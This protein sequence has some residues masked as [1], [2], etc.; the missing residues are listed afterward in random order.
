MKSIS[1]NLANFVP[2]HLTTYTQFTS[3][4]AIEDKIT[5]PALAYNIKNIPVEMPF[6]WSYDGIF[7][8]AN[9]R[10]P[11]MTENIHQLKKD[12]DESIDKT[13]P[14][15]ATQYPIFFLTGIFFILLSIF[16]NLILKFKYK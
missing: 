1:L 15:T 16:I 5:N 13:L 14:P 10:I 3:Y 12:I 8:S 9:R 2:Y 11:I 7:K 6:G 4:I